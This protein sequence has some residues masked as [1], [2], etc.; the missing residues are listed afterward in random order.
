M[1]DLLQKTA[2]GGFINV[3]LFICVFLEN[4]VF[5]NVSAKG[6]DGKDTQLWLGE[7]QRL[8]TYF[9]LT[10]TQKIT[11]TNCCLCGFEASKCIP[12]SL[13]FT[14]QSFSPNCGLATPFVPKAPKMVVPGPQNRPGGLETR[15]ALEAAR[16][17]VEAFQAA[18]QEASRH[19]NGLLR[20]ANRF[21]R[22]ANTTSHRLV[23]RWII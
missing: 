14:T 8:G 22:P 18:C 17:A 2:F 21:L 13:A 23:S 19:G 4:L 9:Y 3:L 11:N 6:G 15:A 1:L 7:G 5:G 10:K 12:R 16:A 20:P